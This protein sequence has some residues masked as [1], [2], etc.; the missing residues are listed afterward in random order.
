MNS[1]RKKSRLRRINHKGE[2]FIE[3]N[4][5]EELSSQECDILKDIINMTLDAFLKLEKLNPNLHFDVIKQ[6]GGVKS[7][8]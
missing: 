3:D 6:I 7:R 5:K 2:W 4:D 1:Q 8:G